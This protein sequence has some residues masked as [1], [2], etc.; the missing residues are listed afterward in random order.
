MGLGF[1]SSVI[2]YREQF[3]RHSVAGVAL[4]GILNSQ[5]T[6]EVCI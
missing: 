3:L 4:L 2:P 6:L 5:E 1:F